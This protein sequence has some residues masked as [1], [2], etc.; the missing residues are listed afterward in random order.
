MQEDEDVGKMAQGA[1]AAVGSEKSLSS[2][3]LLRMSLH[4]IVW[5]NGTTVSVSGHFVILDFGVTFSVW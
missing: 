4:H 5:T 2:C 1:P 3:Q